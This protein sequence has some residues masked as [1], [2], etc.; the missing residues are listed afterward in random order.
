MTGKMVETVPLFRDNP[1]LRACAA[2]VVSCD[3]QGI[4]L[5][6]TVYYPRGGGQPGD[7]GVM[8]LSDG[9]IMLIVDTVK[10][11]G[12]EILHIPSPIEPMPE[13]GMLVDL[14]IDWKRRYMLMRTHTCLHLLMTLVPGQINGAQVSEGKGRIDF[15]VEL[16]SLDKA[17]LEAKLNALIE[18]DLHISPRWIDEAELKAKPELVRTMA[19]SP[20]S[21]GGRV[22]LI[23]IEEIDLQ[24]CGGTHV[25]STGEVGR[26][27]VVKI[28]NKGR[29]NRRVS[30]ELIDE[31][32]DF[33]VSGAEFRLFP[34]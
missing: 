21:S 12:D 17:D 28:D 6:R 4:R 16:C 14:V 32:P 13:P 29:H 7:S 15:D 20:P 30:V 18:R 24:P 27:R 31:T 9:R 33:P 22:R 23:D 8:R 19:V 25:A 26:V 1:Y 5:D 10:G 34:A 2:R 3:D 11:E